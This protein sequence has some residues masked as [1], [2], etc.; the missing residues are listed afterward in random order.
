MVIECKICHKQFKGRKENKYC[1]RKCFNISHSIYMKENNVA[2]S[3]EARLK[4]S[5][6]KKGANNAMWENGRIK[7]DGGY[8]LIHSPEY[9]CRR[10]KGYVLEHRLVMEK[11]IGRYLFPHEV[12]HHIN[13]I[14]TD[15]RIE[16]LA[17]CATPQEHHNFHKK[18]NCKVDGCDRPHK[19]K[20]LCFYHYNKR[21]RSLYFTTEEVNAMF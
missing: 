13:G 1:S 21:K 14:K 8:I 3:L 11:H 12:V 20:D 15:N 2:K 16:N 4:I 19:S 17:L 5:L 6:A 7:T 18:F 9:P 10:N